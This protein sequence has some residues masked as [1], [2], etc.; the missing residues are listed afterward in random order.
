MGNE[1]EEGDN[2]TLLTT[3]DLH[4]AIFDFVKK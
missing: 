1:Q 3:Y 4:E 2:L